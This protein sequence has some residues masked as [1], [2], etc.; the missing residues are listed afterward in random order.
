MIHP[1]VSSWGTNR[2][3]DMNE[4][5]PDRVVPF[6]VLLAATV[7]FALP[8]S[9]QTQDVQSRVVTHQAAIANPEEAPL[10]EWETGY[11]KALEAARQLQSSARTRELGD[12]IELDLVAYDEALREYVRVSERLRHKDRAMTA[13]LDELKNAQGAES[14]TFQTMSN[15]MKAGHDTVK[16]MINNIR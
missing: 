11:A 10:T 16:N 1:N 4:L 12:Q 6:G 13:S 15:T 14:R 9:A 2:G 8:A 5:R 7:V 3:C